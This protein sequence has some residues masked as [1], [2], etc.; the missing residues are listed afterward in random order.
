VQLAGFV[1]L[2]T[3][4]YGCLQLEQDGLADED[5]ASLGAKKLD[6]VFTKL[7]LLSGTRSTD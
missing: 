4:L 2:T 3:D 6:L 7:N 5:L 1:V